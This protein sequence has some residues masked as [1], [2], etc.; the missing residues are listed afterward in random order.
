MLAIIAICCNWR[1]SDIEWC[2]LKCSR[3][4]VLT[5]SE[6]GYGFTLPK[7]FIPFLSIFTL[8]QQGTMQAK[9]CVSD[10]IAHCQKNVNRGKNCVASCTKNCLVIRWLYEITNRDLFCKWK[11]PWPI[12]YWER[13]LY[14]FQSIK[15]LFWL[16]LGLNKWILSSGRKPRRRVFQNFRCRLL[17]KELINIRK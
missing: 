16:N 12:S 8:C 17:E 1:K 5:I 9:Y 10:N 2:Y 11:S 14:V 6:H 13:R 3:R 15:H 4:K 7:F